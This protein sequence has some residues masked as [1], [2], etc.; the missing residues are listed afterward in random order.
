MADGSSFQVAE[1]DLDSAVAL[2]QRQ[3]RGGGVE[4]AAGRIPDLGPLF[5]K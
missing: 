3:E 1:M 4:R 2:R 5:S